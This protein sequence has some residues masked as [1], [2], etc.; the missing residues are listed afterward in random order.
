MNGPGG[1]AQGKPIRRETMYDAW[2]GTS[3][4]SPHVAAAAALLL[5]KHGSMSPSDVRLAL[6]R[7]AFKVPAMGKAAFD[8]DYGAGRLD[9]TALLK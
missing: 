6:T 9:L 3:M 1:I 5:A 7:S 8:Q 2:D 4:A